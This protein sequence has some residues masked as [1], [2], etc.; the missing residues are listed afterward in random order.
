[1]KFNYQNVANPEFFSENRV[2]A[3]SDHVF[4]KN[5]QEAEMQKSS[6]MHSLNGLWKFHYAKNYESTIKGFEQEGYDCKKWDDIRVPAHIQLEGYDI[7]QYANVE[8]PWDGVE[9]IVPGEIPQVLNPVASYAKYFEVPEEF[10]GLQEIFISFQGVES[11][12]ALWLNGEYVGYSEDTFT[13]SDFL[14]TPYLKKGINKLAVQVFKWSGGSWLEDQDFY[15][16]SGIFRD[17]FLY[18]VPQVH[19]SDLKI[20]TLLDENYTNADLQIVLKNDGVEG[21]VKLI[22]KYQNSCVW[23]H[24]SILK[25][26]TFLEQTIEAPLFWSAEH[27]NLY[28]LVIEVYSQVDELLEVIVEPVGFRKFEIKDNIMLINGK[29]IEFKGVNRHEFGIVNG[30][31]MSIED[32]ITDLVTMKQN[33][34]NAVRTSHY[35]NNSFF[36]KLCDLYGLYVIDEVNMETHGV[37][38]GIQRSGSKDFSDSI[39]GDNPLWLENVLNRVNNLYQRDKNHPCVV[40]W[41]L[42]NESCGGKDIYEMSQ[43]FRKLDDTRII[44]Y[45]GIYYDRRFNDSSDVESRMY[46]PASE[47]EEWVKTDTSKPYILCEYAHSMGNSLGAIH[48]Y[49]DLLEKYP[50]FQGGFIWDYID[51]GI[52]A[53]DRYG[54]EYIA[55]GGDFDDYPNDGD[56]CGNGLVYG[57]RTAKPMM[58]EVKFVYQGIQLW[59][60]E[61]QVLIKNRFLFTNTSEYDCIVVVKKEGKVVAAA[62]LQT[63]VKPMQQQTYN[64]PVQVPCKAGEYTITVSMLLKEDT[65]WANKGHEVAFGQAV[66]KVDGDKKRTPEK[67]PIL[68]QGWHNIGVQGDNFKALFSKLYGG[69]VSYKYGGVEM[70]KSSPRPNFWRAPTQNDT[71]NNMAARYGQWLLASRYAIDHDIAQNTKSNSAKLESPVVRQLENSVEVCYTYM[72]PTNPISH[73]SITY[74]VYADGTIQTTLSYEPVERL[75]PMPEFGVMLKMDADFDTI[76]WYGN[77]VEETYADRKHGAKIDVYQQ[78]VVDAVAHYNVPQETGNKTD[79][80]WAKVIN[81]KG[82]GLLFT[83]DCMEFSALPYTPFELENAMHYYE[84]PPVH[85]TV[86]RPAMQRMGI[87]GD[88]SW[89]AVTHEEYLLQVDKPLMFTFTFKGI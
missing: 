57:D 36:Y 65:T 32:T 19:I 85:Y 31:V 77:G 13:P 9:Q 50:T 29:R 1:M 18:A 33:N 74:V 48:K 27:P 72:L 63:D 11:A 69:L 30:R 79:V 67:A 5:L 66:V 58:Q 26:E 46:P 51:Q 59:V 28:D 49:T 75:T 68:I 25:E 3:H 53:K 55:Y 34:I 87:A 88:D 45:E 37:W 89:G 52:L 14:L 71:G 76:E 23:Q 43:L 17:V 6:Y 24:E 82:R 4:Y 81:K 70:L 73:A 78:K 2:L 47:V 56:F 12:F 16:F 22:L 83:A 62:N 38:D 84:L 15:R 10:E 44:H 35:P 86:V 80:R 60:E 42:G 61:K 39:P 7:P 21:K 41:S 64:L 40:I 54:K 20:K 8:Y